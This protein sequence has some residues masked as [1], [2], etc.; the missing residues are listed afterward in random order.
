MGRVQYGFIEE[1]RDRINGELDV[2]TGV[3]AATRLLMTAAQQLL[4]VVAEGGCVGDALPI[5]PH[6]RY[7]REDFLESSCQQPSTIGSLPCLSGRRC[8]R[9]TIR[10]ASILRRYAA[11]TRRQTPRRART[12]RLR[13]S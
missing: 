8:G 1:Y 13:P 9:H 3:P 12:H 6:A 11:R 10:Y 5:G 7:G 2:F 4:D